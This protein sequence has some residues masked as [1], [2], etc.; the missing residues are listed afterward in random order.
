MLI[1]KINGTY[2]I[3]KRLNDYLFKRYY[4]GYTLQE[5]KKMFKQE[6]AKELN[7]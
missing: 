2:H 5:C 6:Y 4:I 3:E 7:K 1:R